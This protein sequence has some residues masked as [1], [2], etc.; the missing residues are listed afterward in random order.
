VYI[1]TIDLTIG[2]GLLL[3]DHVSDRLLRPHASK[4]IIREKMLQEGGEV[5][6]L[7][8]FAC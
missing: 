8:G 2:C 6:F 7:T 1:Y 3:V 5:N 4:H